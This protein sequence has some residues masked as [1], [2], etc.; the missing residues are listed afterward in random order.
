LHY[1]Q[2]EDRKHHREALLEAGLP[3]ERANTAAPE[4][5]TP[6]AGIGKAPT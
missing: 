4:T 1:K 6:S 2:A 5:A 3:V